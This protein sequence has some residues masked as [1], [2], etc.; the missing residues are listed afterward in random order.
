MCA[1]GK[2]APADLHGGSPIKIPNVITFDVNFDIK[3][4]LGKAEADAKAKTASAASAADPGNKHQR[5][6]RRNPS[7]GIDS[8]PRR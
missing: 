2:V 4:Y 3:N 6:R 1:V 8:G 7:G 5:H